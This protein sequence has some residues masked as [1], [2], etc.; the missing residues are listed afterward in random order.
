M[1]QGQHN[2]NPIKVKQI[3]IASPFFN[4]AQLELVHHVENAI[5]NTDGLNFYSP[6]A[7]GVLQDMTHE[8]R[9]AR[10][11]ELFRL[12][13]KMIMQC[14]SVLA[15][16]THKDEGTIWETGYAYGKKPVF[17]YKPGS[18]APMNIM[19][20][21]CFNAV[22]YDIDQLVRFLEAYSKGTLDETHYKAKEDTF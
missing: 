16:K 12:N 10:G 4:P 22:V 13:C 20:A 2:T 18:D 9:A 8:Q 19:S 3:Y 17:A 11:P 15:I 21:C 1:M 7:D 14:D 6:R 5:R